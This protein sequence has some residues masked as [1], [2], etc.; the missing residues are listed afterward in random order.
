LSEFNPDVTEAVQVSPRSYADDPASD[1]RNEDVTDGDDDLV[2]RPAAPKVVREREG[3]PTG[4]RMR[5]DEHYVE[6][7]MSKRETRDGDGAP[8][9][10][11]GHRAR[12]TPRAAW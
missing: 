12:S 2:A 3:L 5:A 7:L 8:P 4:Y 9:A 10:A 11:S 1:I 6:S